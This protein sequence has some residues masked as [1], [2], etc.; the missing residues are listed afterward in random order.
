MASAQASPGSAT[1]G[2]RYAW[3]IEHY[4]APAI[5]HVP[6]TRLR[7]DH[8]HDLYER[9]GTTGGRNGDGLAPTTVLEV[10]M[11]VRAALDLAVQRRLLD[12]NVAHA[13]HGP[14]APSGNRAGTL[15]E[16][17]FAL[18]WR[19]SRGMRMVADVR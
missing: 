4:I 15:M 5:G 8:L 10:P 13:A 6:P 11:I 17:R 9:L 16:S 12:H 2:Y 1:T 3:F 14:P 7:A 19:G 18:A